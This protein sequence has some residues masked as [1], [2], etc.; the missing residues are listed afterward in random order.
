MSGETRN[1]I[2]VSPPLFQVIAAE[3]PFT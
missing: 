1:E 3:T 2:F